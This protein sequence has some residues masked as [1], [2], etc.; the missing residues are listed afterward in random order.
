[1]EEREQRLGSV[2]AGWW[3][4]AMNSGKWGSNQA[5]DQ[6]AHWLCLYQTPSLSLWLKH[7]DTH[8]HSHRTQSISRLISEGGINQAARWCLK[9]AL[10][11]WWSCWKKAIC[12]GASEISAEISTFPSFP[13]EM[14]GCWFHR[15]SVIVADIL[16]DSLGENTR[17]GVGRMEVNG[18]VLSPFDH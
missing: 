3:K 11:V 8:Q 15:D 2:P 14:T 16:M 6:Q 9:R 5:V 13:M 12:S 7:P 4:R 18:F 1:M 17:V 10:E